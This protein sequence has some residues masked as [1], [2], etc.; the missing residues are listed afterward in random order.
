MTRRQKI[1]T[2]FCWALFLSAL[3]VSWAEA[4]VQD[5]LWSIPHRLSSLD[6]EADSAA[7]TADKYGYVHV[8]WKETDFPDNRSI[9]QYARFDGE[10][11]TTP[12]DIY[13]TWPSIPIGAVTTYVDHK[14]ILHLAWSE[15]NSGPVYHTS[16]PAYDT[17]SAQH[18]RE[19]LRMDI[20]A[21]EFGLRVDSAGVLHVLY[22]KLRA[23]KQGIYYVRSED[24]GI[25]WSDPL[26][27]DSDIPYNL[28]PLG[29]A[30]AL[31]ENGG[32]HAMWYYFAPDAP[33]NPGGW[34]RYA[35]SL[36]GG[37]NWSLPITIDRDD[38]GSNRLAMAGPMMIVTGPN[39]HIIWAGG[40]LLYRHHRFSNDA[41]RTW[42]APQRIFGDLHGQAGDGAAVDA[43]GRVH[44]IGQIRYP[45]GLY[46]AYW[47]QDHWTAPS[48]FYLIAHD[49]SDPIGDRIH[50]HWVRL[51]LRAGN[52][53]VT[54]FTNSPSDPQRVLY[55]M[56]RTLE[57]IPPLSAVPTPI[58]APTLTPQPSP[59][60]TPF[61]PT[62]TPKAP[63]SDSSA[64]PPPVNGATPGFA[65]WL[66]I[67]PSLLLITSII[68]FRSLRK[69]Y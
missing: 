7:M 63:P 55:A 16:A 50:A 2:V 11:W 66:G 45:Q 41:G 33:G 19:P 28:S 43:A 4:Q 27:L 18:W 26:W 59:T 38:D 48:L 5:N 46:H 65:L 29:L 14:G 44:Y 25:T 8:F 68:V 49:A 37:H 51:A 24:G 1:R 3:W 32:L 34:I 60:L 22:S 54:T 30:F 40:E 58:S 20:P 13:V 56:H 69:H 35:H 15:G 47:D 52:Q 6:G 61:V 21:Y 31:D 12:I 39:V 23:P 57:D 67:V 10:T 36:D 64:A 42:G 53:L 62:P 9:I 17:L